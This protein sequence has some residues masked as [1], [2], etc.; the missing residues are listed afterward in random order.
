MAGVTRVPQDK[1][2]TSQDKRM[3]VKCSHCGS[4]KHAMAKCP[5]ATAQQPVED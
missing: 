2:L 4:I 1:Q 3:V 5:T